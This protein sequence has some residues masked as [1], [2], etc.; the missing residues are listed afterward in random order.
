MA[1]DVAQQVFVPLE[2]QLGVQSALH[3]NLIAPQVDGFLDLLQQHVAI[4]QVAFGVLRLAEERA[5]VA[6]G[7]ADVRVVDVA[8]DVVRA[9]RLGMQAA[10]HR[11]GR[12]PQCRQI[13]AL[14]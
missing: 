3:Q 12:A 14:Q 7:R 1:L 10:R 11:V 8:V 4:Q 5:E 9:I 13:V 6:H 2:R